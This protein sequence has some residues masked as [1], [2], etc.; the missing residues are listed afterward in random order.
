MRTQSLAGAALAL[1][2]PIAPALA[3]PSFALSPARFGDIARQVTGFDG[4]VHTATSWDFIECVASR[5][6]SVAR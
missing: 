6:A 2:L 1:A 4:G 3:A 5:A